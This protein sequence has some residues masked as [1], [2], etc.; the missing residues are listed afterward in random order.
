MSGHDKNTITSSHDGFIEKIK[1]IDFNSKPVPLSVRGKVV[2]PLNIENSDHFVNFLI[3]KKYVFNSRE[4]KDSETDATIVLPLPQNLSTGYSAQYNNA[5]LGPI[6][7][8]VAGVANDSD[9][10]IGDLFSSKSLSSLKKKITTEAG[11]NLASTALQ[12]ELAPLIGAGVGRALT[13]QLGTLAGAAAGYA[14]GKAVEGAFAGLGVAANPHLAVLFSG[15]DF[16]K[17][18]FQYRL[19]PQSKQE[20][21]NLR[22]L[23]K[24]FKEAMLPSYIKDKHFFRYPRQ[25]DIQIPLGDTKTNEYLF[26]IA[27][28]VLTSF[29][30]NY[31]PTGPHFHDIGG[32]KAPVAVDIAMEFLE[33]SVTTR[34]DVQG[35]NR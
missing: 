32:K 26:D 7:A 34:Q 13:G 12:S 21:D 19:V 27:T 4:I 16:R 31:Q 14:T 23:I 22:D 8:A 33:T 11:L 29:T 2:F 10:T 5:Q 1:N 15:P 17:H 24:I 20:Q 28:S 6:G 25:F 18:S 30:V 9:G 3:S 35:G